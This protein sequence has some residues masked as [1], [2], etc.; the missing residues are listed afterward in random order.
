MPL[1]GEQ[2]TTD[3]ALARQDFYEFHIPTNLPAASQFIATT[4][5]NGQASTQIICE[6]HYQSDKSTH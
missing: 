3:N 1:C 2:G 4:I 5:R 6:N